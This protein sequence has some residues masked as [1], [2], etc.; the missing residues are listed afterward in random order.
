MTTPS[1]TEHGPAVGKPS[2]EPGSSLALL[3]ISPS[4]VRVIR[5]FVVHP[6]TPVHGR[7]LQRILGLGSAS[8]QRDLERL[9]AMGALERIQSG[10]LVQYRPVSASTLW[11][12]L[13]IL[14]LEG[15][16][17]TAIV[18]DAL[19]DVS[20]IDA[21]F[22]FGSTAKGTARPDSDIDLFVVESPTMD[23]R[24]LNTQLVYAGLIL[25]RQINTVKYSP[26]ALAE[27]LGNAQHAA[28]RFVRELLE[29]P[30]RWVVGSADVL[31]PL[32]TASGIAMAR[33]SAAA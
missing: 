18:R 31:R 28:H 24:A 14:V 22:V 21:A 11:E 2:E 16:E 20:G 27:R 26:L 3:G 12:A 5:Y 9:V 29:G 10:R 30:K 7:H 23:R 33:A 4:T 19:C 17:A 15:T 1:V 32:A 8:V 25:N 6:E 13:R